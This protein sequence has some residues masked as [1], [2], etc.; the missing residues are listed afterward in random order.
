MS[1]SVISLARRAIQDQNPSMTE[2]D[3]G[4]AFALGDQANRGAV[5]SSAHG[6]ARAT[7]DVDL[8]A[9]L[10]PAKIGALV[11]ALQDT[12]YIDKDAALDAI[13]RRS[14]FNVVHLDTMLK[15]DIYM[16][17][18]R[19]FDRSSF[20]RRTQVYLEEGASAMNS[21]ALLRR[22]KPPRRSV[23]S[24]VMPHKSYGVGVQNSS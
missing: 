12:Y 19:E 9:D 14:M 22:S 20:S 23:H 13:T 5:A 3:V 7:L 16:L 15:V 21:F 2:Q 18:K 24:S 8:V 11:A 6:I 10:V 4:L 1:S 17:T